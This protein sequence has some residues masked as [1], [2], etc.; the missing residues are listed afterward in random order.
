MPPLRLLADD[1]TGALDSAARF[2]PV[3]GPVAV[4]WREATDGSLAFDTGTRDLAAGAA[5]AR[6]SEM[7]ALLEGGDPAFKKIDS[8]LRGHVALELAACMRCF[9]HC[10]L[11]P[12]FPFQ[13]RITR[14]GRQ[15]VREG[16]AW[17]DTG[18]DLAA[19]LRA[20]GLDR[21][22]EGLLLLTGKPATGADRAPG[23]RAGQR[24]LA[25]LIVAGAPAR[26]RLLP[27][28]Q[29]G[30]DI[31]NGVTQLPGMHRSQPQGFKDV[32]GL[33]TPVGEFDGH[34]RTPDS[35]RFHVTPNT[36]WL[37]APLL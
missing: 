32:I 13:G 36:G 30:G 35:G 31:D 34:R 11:A 5:L 17:R 4:T 19:E 28:A 15:L 25:P 37:L 16:E 24:P 8:L 33:G 27:D 1:L 9:D 7:A 14:N 2:V 6:V 23:A 29:D 10:V 26:D 12:A 22:L 3:S 20:L 18:I 21:L